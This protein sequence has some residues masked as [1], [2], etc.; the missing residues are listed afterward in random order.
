MTLQANQRVRISGE[1]G[2]VIGRIEAMLPVDQLPELA[3][4]GFPTA[5]EFAP[6][7]IMREF[8]IERVATI[9]YHAS[10]NAEF[11]FTAVE[12]GGEWYDLKRNKLTL[13]VV[14][15]FQ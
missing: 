14:G 8:G 12:I 3:E 2:T 6:K 11:L 13:E 1:A 9:S 10:P 7:S 15:A 4:L 5:G